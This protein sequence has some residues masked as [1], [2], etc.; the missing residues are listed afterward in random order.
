LIFS[1]QPFIIERMV[2]YFYFL[3]FILGTA[4]GSF[5]GVVVD[6]L[7]SKEPI[8]KGRS[9]C[10]HCRHHLGPLDLVPLVSYFLLGRKCRYCHKELSWFYPIIELCTGLAFVAAGYTVFHNSLVQASLL[11]YQLLALYYFSLV[12]SLLVIFFADF[13]YGIIPFKAV[14]FAFLLTLLWYIIF[15]YLAFSSFQMHLLGLQTNL[16]GIA[17]SA[18]AAGGFFFLLFAATKGRGM[19]FG[20]VIYAFLM[21]FTLGFPKV[22][23]GLYLAFVTGAVVSIA[24]VLLKKKKF[25]GGTIPFGPFLVLGTMISLFWGGIVLDY[26]L[27]YI[28]S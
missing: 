28:I 3:I 10:D 15:P 21:G 2:A 13:K 19:G 24:L 14:V 1:L 18:I 27:R 8:W 26:V 23:I 16:F 6:R 22:I 11:S 25:K 7:A 4:I 17:L 5:L 12:S 20:D 9:H